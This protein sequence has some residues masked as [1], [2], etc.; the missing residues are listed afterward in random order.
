MNLVYLYNQ[1][2]VIFAT[3]ALC[4]SLGHDLCIKCSLHCCYIIMC[5]L[6]FLFAVT[7]TIKPI[8]LGDI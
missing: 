8:V 5:F 3:L 4:G 1:C 7:A 6:A 2:N